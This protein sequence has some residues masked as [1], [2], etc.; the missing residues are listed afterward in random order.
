[1]PDLLALVAPH[2]AGD[3]MRETKWLNCR[4]VDV[5]P[6]LAAQE[7]CV[8]TPVISRLLHA[9]AYD[10]RLNVKT[11]EGDSH[12]QRDEQFQYIQAQQAHHRAAGQPQ[13]SVDTKKKELIGDFKN[14][15]RSWG[16][17]AE[18]VNLHDFPSEAVGRAVPYGIYDEQHNCGT[19]Y[20]GQSA[21]TPAFAVDN[22]VRWC[23]TEM[24]E[25]FPDA[26]ALMIKADGG[27]SNSSRS[28]VW[29]QQLQEKVADCFGLTITVCHYPTGT[30]KWNPIEHRL[31][32]EISKTWAGCP[33][34]SFEL[35]LQYIRE[36]TTQTGLTV[37]AWLVTDDYP[38]GLTVSDEAMAALNLDPHE[39]CPQWNYT[40]RPR[41]QLSAN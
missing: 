7:H 9:Q 17:T 32:S 24:P 30:S 14:P 26:R 40:I 3:P 35:T 38:T 16:P 21:D 20:L 1:M 15:G 34:R 39:V 37:Q 28:R 33:L 10:L 18:R 5:Q 41:T 31:F 4:L 36:T 13:I 6:K 25:R 19:V 27:G 29:K 8:S 22:I 12:P 23:E 2:T 11:L